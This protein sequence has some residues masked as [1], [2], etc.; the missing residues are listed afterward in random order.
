MNSP[1]IAG[2][3]ATSHEVRDLEIGGK[4]AKAVVVSRVYD[5]DAADLWDAITR[6]E[7]LARSFLPVS[8]DLKV[9]GRYQF[10]GNA[11]G[12]ITE[13]VPNKRVAATWEFG[14]GTSWVVVTLAPDGSGT[15]LTLE[16]SA[17][18]HPMWGQFGSGAVG[19]G[20]DL[21]M[22]GMGLH[23][24]A[25]DAERPAQAAAEWPTTPEGQAYIREAAEAW[26]HAD[27]AAGTP[28][29]EAMASAENSRKFYTGE[30]APGA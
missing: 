26:G 10:E 14:G 9:G 22:M 30:S 1:L 28:R 18:L 21:A 13:C 4:P 19:I 5:T 3:R 11:G 8:G 27:M 23:L 25:P 2:L 24:T 12:T 6:P 16:H 29:D 20:W 7:R 17:E 15:R